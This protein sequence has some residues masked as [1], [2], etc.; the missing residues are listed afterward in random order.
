MALH[1]C[2]YIHFQFIGV[3]TDEHVEELIT[4]KKWLHAQTAFIISSLETSGYEFKFIREL[5]TFRHTQH[6]LRQRLCVSD[7]ALLLPCGG[8]EI[9]L[10]SSLSSVQ[11]EDD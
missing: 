6:T 10:H 8:G 3:I 11:E 4:L 5:H 9:Q 7:R 1:V 2:I